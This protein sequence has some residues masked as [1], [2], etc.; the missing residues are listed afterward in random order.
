VTPPWVLPLAVAIIDD[1]SCTSPVLLI[2]CWKAKWWNDTAALHELVL[3][4]AGVGCA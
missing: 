3:E 1:R 2:A 4:A